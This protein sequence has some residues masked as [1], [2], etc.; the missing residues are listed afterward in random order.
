MAGWTIRPLH[1]GGIRRD[2]AIF[3]HLRNMGT[4]IDI[5]LIA[6]YLEGRGLR[7]LVDTGGHDPARDPLHQPYQREPGQDPVAR[8][9]A[10]GVRPEEVDILILT[11]LHWDHASNIHLFPNARVVV[12]REEL[13]FAAAPLPFLSWPYRTLPPFSASSERFEAVDGDARIAEGVTVH[14]TPGHT[15]G[16]QGVAVRTSGA[17]YFIASDNVPLGESWNAREKYGVSHWP[18]GLHVDL[19]AYFKSLR[20]TEDLGDV[21]LP[22]HDWSV[23][24]RGEYR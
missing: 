21:I 22:S 23:L 3:T 11:H 14:L 19:E 9:S 16:L 12:Q 1:V 18:N 6:W 15:P 4:P 7:I 2:K 24:E 5:P 20:R 10:L 8:L 13:R 17:A